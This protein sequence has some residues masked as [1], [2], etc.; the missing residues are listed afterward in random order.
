MTR[1]QDEIADLTPAQKAALFDHLRKKRQASGEQRRIGRRASGSPP[2][3]S[4]GQLR[5]W[6]LDRLSPG[7]PTYNL[8]TAVEIHG[9]LD[10]PAL[11]QALAAV[12]GRHEVLRTTFASFAAGDG[13]E[14]V[15]VIAP[16]F[17]LRLPVIELRGLPEG[18][19]DAELRRWTAAAASL[20]FD[21]EKGPLLR[22]ALFRIAGGHH[23]LLVV[24]HHSVSDGW[25]LGLL[26]QEMAA[27]YAASLAGRPSPLPELAIQYADFAAWERQTLRGE[28]L[29]LLVDAWRRRLA[30]A[31][32]AIALPADRP[33]PPLKTSTGAAVDLS[34]PPRAA[35]R[36]T[37]LAAGVRGTCFMGL[38]AA[39]NALLFRFTG[40]TD[41]VV[42]TPVANRRPETSDLIGFFVNTLALRCDL[43]GDPTFEE[44]LGRVREVTLEAFTHQA[45]PFEKLVEEL[46]PE[47][48][49]SRTPLFQVM[50]TLQNAPAEA[51]DLEG[52]SLRKVDSGTSSAKFDL[53][54]TAGEIGEEL[55]GSLTYWTE[56]FDAATVARLGRCFSALVTAV[57]ESPWQRISEIPILSREEIA[58]LTQGWATP[59]LPAGD[60]ALVHERIA[61]WATVD[62]ARPALQ[63]E[64]GEITYGELQRRTAELAS[65]LRALGVGPEVRVGVPGA[66]SASTVVGILAVLEAGGAYVPLDPALPED[67]RA[68]LLEEAGCAVV[69]DRSDR[70]DRTD[71]SD[72]LPQLPVLPENAAYV[73]FTSGSTGT[74][75]GVVVEHRQLARYVDGAIAA[76]GLPP[77]ARYALVSTF[78]ADLGHT[79]LF[80]AL[81]TGGCL[82]VV[83]EA[84][85]A[86]PEAFADHLE[87][88]PADCLK[89]VPSHLAALLGSSRP[90]AALPRRR[91]VLGGEAT[92]PELARRLRELAPELAVFNHYGPT[93]TTVGAIAGPLQG[94]AA[95]IPLGRPLP[96]VQILLFGTA[97]ELVPVGVVGEI[98]IGGGGVARGYLGRP[99]LTAE[100]FVPG[101]GGRLYR[102]G[103]L[104]RLTKDGLVWLGRADHQVKIRGFRIELGEVE[105]ALVRQPG[106]REAVVLAREDA[107]GDRR[108]VAYVVLRE[109]GESTDLRS[110]LRRSLPEAMVPS[111]V[112]TLES[113]PL[114]AN[115]KVDRRALARMASAAVREEA[116]FTAPQ[117]PAEELLA[118]IWAEVLG[119]GRL[120]PQAR[121]G[122]HDDF[123]ALGG[124]SLLATRVISR[125]REAFGV[126]VPLR[127]LF[128]TPTVAELAGRI[129]RIGPIGPSGPI[130]RIERADRTGDLPLSF[131]QQRLWFLDRLAPDNPFYNVYSPLRLNGALDVTAL[132]RAFREIVRRQ[133]GLRTAFPV[134]DGRPRQAIAPVA[135]FQLPLIDLE[136]LPGESWRAE[137]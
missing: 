129:E 28:R 32:P 78:A 4:F 50:C 112:V 108:L 125:I 17:E 64:D 90:A 55:D 118:G 107:P 131:A 84:S 61:A 80:P 45:M 130:G 68:A 56:I 39:W 99:G 19:R 43:A 18:R 106:V 42:G 122:A 24:M 37:G 12:A 1:L 103:D 82:D 85:A 14:P 47:R 100:R 93:E 132:R 60:A 7:D 31:P 51:V 95:T 126:E 40:A 72:L 133:E 35:A 53:S 38:L 23:L 135:D 66:R 10:V 101:P 111:E 114:T 30:G 41:L 26:V 8:P 87:R 127:A 34:F 65:R 109:T 22:N 3:L 94:S 123:F 105:A 79:S 121:I 97:G 119:A 52:L 20:P 75:K 71:R 88:Y 9:A 74:P 49:P 15:Q 137:L 98:H 11:T 89:I 46:S 92:S 70:S 6:F 62:P 73:L 136:G 77:G 128:E 124:H 59:A 44:L 13:D 48:D 54:L 25:S 76:L 36:L 134:M 67:R 58:E 2:P 110:A 115:G 96:G 69:L 16:R 29:A 91:L 81:V 116:H 63:G 86:D 117:G 83:P 113:L 102:T 21:L 5:L 104:A 120:G 57:L 33:R 27:L